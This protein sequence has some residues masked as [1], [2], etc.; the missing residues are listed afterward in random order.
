M[1][2][3]LLFMQGREIP[4]VHRVIKVV[5]FELFTSI[6]AMLNLILDSALFPAHFEF[7]LLFVQVH[8]RQDTAE[9]DILTKG[10]PLSV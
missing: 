2:I 6:D 1:L 8:E 3:W 7:T 9:V 5:H 4:I 10:I